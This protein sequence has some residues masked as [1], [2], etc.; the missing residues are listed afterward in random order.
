MSRELLWNVQSF[1]YC[2]VSF[3]SNYIGY[4]GYNCSG[5]SV[6]RLADRAMEGLA[7]ATFFALSNR[8]S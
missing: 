5:V 1:E 2:T 6:E 4:T 3:A 8:V 7:F